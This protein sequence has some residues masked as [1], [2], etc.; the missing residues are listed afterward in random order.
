MK[1]AFRIILASCLFLQITCN[2]DDDFKKG[3]ARIADKIEKIPASKVK[4]F[5]YSLD[6]H[7][8]RRFEGKL[9]EN[10]EE[11]F[12]WIPILGRVEI[13]STQEKTNLLFAFAKG[14]RE[15]NGLVASCF[16]PRHGIRIVTETTTNDF[17]ICF[18]CLQVE[19]HGFGSIQGFETSGSPNATF[20]KFLDEY[21]IKKA[22]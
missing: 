17:V 20:N 22:E 15:C 13:V 3:Q 8:V 12:H 1:L 19:A 2:A 11:S 21:K 9:P 7:D 14:V 6:P 10:S 16:D 18:E 4:L 5:L